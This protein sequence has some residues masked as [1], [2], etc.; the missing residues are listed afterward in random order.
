[1]VAVVIVRKSEYRHREEVEMKVCEIFLSIQGEGPSA[2]RPAVFLRLA[3]CNLKCAWCDSK[4][5][6]TQWRELTVEEVMETLEQMRRRDER[7]VITGGEPLLQR[8]EVGKLLDLAA[9]KFDSLWVEVETNGT[10]VLPSDWDVSWRVS[11]KLWAIER[12][13]DY[14]WEIW[15]L[16]EGYGGLILKWVVSTKW[17]VD[18]VAELVQRHRFPR[19]SVYLMPLAASREEYLKVAPEVW[20]WCIEYGFRFSPRLQII[21]WDTKRGV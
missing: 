17:E 12:Y 8:D 13:K 14:H 21:H 3:G 11:P 1:M 7:L 6:H 4:Y 16:L 15:K 18:T 19:H 5:A 20:K 10:L 9:E 2:G